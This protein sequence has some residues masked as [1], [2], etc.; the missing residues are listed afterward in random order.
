HCPE[1]AQGGDE[2]VQVVTDVLRS[3]ELSLHRITQELEADYRAHL[4]AKHVLA[5][6]NGT[7]AIFASLH[8]LGLKPGDEVLVPSA[9]YWASVMPVLWCGAIPVFCETEPDQ[10]GLDP[11]DLMRYA[12]EGF[13]RLRNL[14]TQDQLIEMLDT[15][16]SHFH[17]SGKAF[18]AAL[19]RQPDAGRR[20]AV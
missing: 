4:G 11:A 20:Q 6:C 1:V 10:L 7:S 2:D 12:L 9:T 18:A 17:G 5:C 13:A 8:A 3:G 16:E 15:V 14:A 19:A